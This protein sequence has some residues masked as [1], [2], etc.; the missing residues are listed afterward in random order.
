MSDRGFLFLFSIVMIVG[1]LASAGWLIATG[2]A[3]TVDGLFL[4]LTALLMALVFGLYVMFV[5]R[6]AMEAAKP[7]ATA[8]AAK[9]A[10]AAAK[11]AAPATTQA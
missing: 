11:P 9:A 7:A 10:P 5:I 6:R 1:S 4:V 2:Q 3:G 8:P